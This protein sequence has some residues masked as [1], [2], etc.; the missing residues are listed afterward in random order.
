MKISLKT[1]LF[2]AISLVVSYSIGAMENDPS[3]RKSFIGFISKLK[4][5]ASQIRNAQSTLFTQNI[6]NRNDNDDGV[7]LPKTEKEE[8]E[9][10]ENTASNDGSEILRLTKLFE[11]E[12]LKE[13]KE[14]LATPE[15]NIPTKQPEK[16]PK[17]EQT[18]DSDIIYFNLPPF[19][20][21]VLTPTSDSLSSELTKYQIINETPQ[22][23]HL[24][25]LDN[26]T[27]DQFSILNETSLLPG[28]NKT[29]CIN[30][31]NYSPR[32]RLCDGS[33]TYSNIASKARLI[34]ENLLKYNTL[35]IYYNDEGKLIV[36]NY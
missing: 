17:D 19:E 12:D 34:E 31:V 6:F 21:T 18:Q 10:E 7:D 9:K 14:L 28:K 30:K 4:T 11:L 5:S 15:Q 13:L 33:L 27:K 8:T 3:K 20:D 35:K 36:F 1:S 22:K 2:L 25:I 32:F 16:T 24:Y 23:M 26:N 29:V